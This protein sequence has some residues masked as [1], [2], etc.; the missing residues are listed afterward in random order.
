MLVLVCDKRGLVSEDSEGKQIVAHRGMPRRSG[1]QF[2]VNLL[3]R[4]DYIRYNSR[5]AYAE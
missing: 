3:R 4:S 5:H 2:L 1:I